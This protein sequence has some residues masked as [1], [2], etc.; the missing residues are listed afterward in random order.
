[1]LSEDFPLHHVK[2]NVSGLYL[3]TLPT[4]TRKIRTCECNVLDRPTEGR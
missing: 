2:D 3:E 4:D 1:M